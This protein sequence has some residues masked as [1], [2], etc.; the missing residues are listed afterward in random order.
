MNDLVG[1]SRSEFE[2]AASRL[3][4]GYAYSLGFRD[5]DDH[6]HGPILSHPNAP[7]A[8]L[9]LLAD[10]PSSTATIGNS[11]NHAGRGQNVLYSDG[12]VAF[13]TARTAGLRGDDIYLNQAN[14]VAAGLGLHDVV[15]GAGAAVP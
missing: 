15:L 7:A 4:P 6:I 10:A 14:R 3:L 2:V 9:P 13:K 11:P 5:E 1:M 12:H 8:Q